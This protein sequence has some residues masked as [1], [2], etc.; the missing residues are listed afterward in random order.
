MRIF[1]PT[2]IFLF[3]CNTIFAQ[4]TSDSVSAD[5]VSVD[6]VF[7]KPD[8]VSIIGVG[9]IMMGTNYPEDKLPPQDGAFLLRDVESILS[10]ADVTFGNLEGTLLDSGGVAKKCKD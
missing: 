4:T 3:F 10:N 2:L 6:S 1:K 7:Q 5:S 9:D 8:T